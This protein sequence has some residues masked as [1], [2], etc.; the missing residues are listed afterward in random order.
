MTEEEYKAEWLQGLHNT[1]YNNCRFADDKV[2]FGIEWIKEKLPTV[3]LDNPQNIVDRINWCKLY[4]LDPRKPL[5][6]DKITV[7]YMLEDVGLKDIIIPPVYYSRCYL[8]KHEL[9]SLP[10]GNYIFKCNHGSGWNIKYE[11]KPGNNPEYLL[12]KL[13]E[14]YN[15]NYA[16]MS[17]WEW[18]YDKIIKGVIVQP[19]LGVLKDWSFWCENGEIKYVQTSR[20]LGKNLAEFMTFTDENGKEP[21]GYIGVKPMRFYLIPSELNIL[22]K[23]KPIVKKLASD[24]KFV[25]VDMYSV[26]GE[27]KFGELTFSPCSGKLLYTGLK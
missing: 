17:G 11:K 26:N 1:E 25:R 23:M 12:S 21:D 3:N 2:K 6:S 15:L 8:T 27:P 18:Q 16:Y 4:D 19:N 9:D 13:K 24:F 20:K 5:W 7:N 10:D 14:W 22:E